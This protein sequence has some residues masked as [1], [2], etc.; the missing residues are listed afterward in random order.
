MSE[1]KLQ[2]IFYVC[3]KYFQRGCILFGPLKI[4]AGSIWETD[5]LPITSSFELSLKETL[6][7]ESINQFNLKSTCD[8]YFCSLSFSLSLM[9]LPPEYFVC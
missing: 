1:M 6:T 7:E 4:N 2:Y 9:L 3:E 5:P 8:L